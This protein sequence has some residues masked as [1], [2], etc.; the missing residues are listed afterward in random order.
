[1]SSV[2]LTKLRRYKELLTSVLRFTFYCR[3][4]NILTAGLSL[5]QIVSF[6]ICINKPVD[7]PILL[8]TKI[9]IKS[10]N[11][12]ITIFT[13][14]VPT[15]LTLSLD[16]FQFFLLSDGRR[17]PL[18]WTISEPSAVLR[19]R[20]QSCREKLMQWE[21][22]WTSSQALTYSHHIIASFFVYF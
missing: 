21:T 18:D 1:M 5:L 6:N 17:N 3:E 9:C 4:H 12:K 7:V 16:R 15:R 13:Y 11:A 14:L 10:Y 20:G 2:F 19:R 22:I 8:R